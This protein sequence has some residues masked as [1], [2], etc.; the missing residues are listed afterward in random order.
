MIAAFRTSFVSANAQVLL[1]TT[2]AY[3][4]K[5]RPEGFF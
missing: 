3:A 5:E 1:L 4:D 2:A